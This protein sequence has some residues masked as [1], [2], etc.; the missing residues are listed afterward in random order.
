MYVSPVNDFNRLN[1]AMAA[2]NMAWWEI[3]LPSG[4]VFFGDHKAA[5]LGYKPDTFVH[6]RNFTDL[7]H[8]DDHD[9]AM[10]AMTDHLEGT[11]DAYET[12]YRIKHKDGHYLTFYDRG[13]IVQRKKGE[14][15]VAGIVI[16]VADALAPVA[17]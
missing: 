16:K 9:Q 5:M 6:Y 8:P 4:V 3:E 15:K 12:T 17:L 11:A 7:L 1:D 13:K 10:K 2:A 14:I